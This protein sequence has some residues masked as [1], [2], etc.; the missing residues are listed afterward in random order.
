LHCAAV[1]CSF[2]VYFLF[3]A[4][5]SYSVLLGVAQNQSLVKMYWTT[6]T[7]AM[8]WIGLSILFVCCPPR[9]KPS[10][11]DDQNERR[12]DD[13]F[14]PPPLYPLQKKN[15]ATCK[16]TTQQP[17]GVSVLLR[18]FFFEVSSRFFMGD[19]KE[20]KVSKKHRKFLPPVIIRR[21]TNKAAWSYSGSC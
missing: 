4:S 13:F 21:R 15:D 10:T 16:M 17:L 19:F 9:T 1:Q 6:N 11:N 12:A 8:Y 2:F 14:H 18:G 7:F 5:V 3:L 20:E